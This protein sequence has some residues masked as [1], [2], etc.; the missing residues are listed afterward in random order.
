MD[1]DAWE[2]LALDVRPSIISGEQSLV[3]LESLRQVGDVILVHDERAALQ[4]RGPPAGALALVGSEVTTQEGT[5]LGRVRAAALSADR[6]GC[7]AA[8]ELSRALAQVRDYEFDPEDGR[9]TALLFDALGV[10]VLP[11]RDQPRS[12]AL[13][14]AAVPAV[15]LVASMRPQPHS[16]GLTQ[17]TLPPQESIMTVY[18]L[19]VSEVVSAGPGRVIVEIG[20]ETR[21]NQARHFPFVALSWLVFARKC[22]QCSQPV[23]YHAC[24]S[25]RHCCS[26]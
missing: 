17:Q 24:R 1:V 12:S 22:M 15:C 14:C 8:Q 11:V 19:P 20:A 6:G 16:S 5:S 25:V 9:I 26:V 3:A 10:P 21:V 23:R 4:R 18:S 13:A 2:V 7:S